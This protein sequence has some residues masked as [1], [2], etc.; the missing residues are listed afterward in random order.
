MKVLTV[1]STIVLPMTVLTGLWGMNVMLP[2]FAGGANAQFWWVVA[3]MGA[4]TV[5]MLAVFRWRRW[6]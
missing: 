1:V 5:G 2:Q 3:I 6:I 4:I